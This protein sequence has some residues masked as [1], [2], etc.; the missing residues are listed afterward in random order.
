MREE[1][2]NDRPAAGLPRSPDRSDRPTPRRCSPC[3][4]LWNLEPETARRLRGRIEAVLDYAREP[5]DSRPN[6]AAGSGWLKTKLGEQSKTE[7]DKKTGERIP[8]W[9]HA[10]M[11]W[12]NV[13]AFVT[14]LRAM[15]SAAS[16]ALEFLVLTASRTGEVIDMPWNEVELVLALD[17]ALKPTW[18]IPSDRRKM[19]RDHHVPPSDRAVEILREQMARR[20]TSSFGDHPYVFEGER[21]RQG[22]SNMALLM[23]R[24]ESRQLSAPQPQPP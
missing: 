19:D 9:H 10:A 24:A 13:P 1:R 2:R 12:Q 15:D 21:P 18:S 7:L 16:R 11:R 17:K 8:R 5:D 4:N 6:P 14:K 3:W 22:L 23:I 20:S